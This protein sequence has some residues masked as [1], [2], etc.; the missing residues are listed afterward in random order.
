MKF[1]TGQRRRS[2]LQG[3]RKRR[4][5][6]KAFES[7]PAPAVNWLEYKTMRQYPSMGDMLDQMR[8]YGYRGGIESIVEKNWNPEDDSFQDFTIEELSR[9]GM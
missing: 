6:L 7:A 8:Q 4:R 9:K 2:R 1:S 5:K 3:H